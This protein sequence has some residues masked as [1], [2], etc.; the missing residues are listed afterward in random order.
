MVRIWVKVIRLHHLRLSARSV[1]KLPFFVPVAPGT[2]I[3]QI[4][5]DQ[6]KRAELGRGANQQLPAGGGVY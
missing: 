6:D 1:S 2:D 4:T 5:D 3:G